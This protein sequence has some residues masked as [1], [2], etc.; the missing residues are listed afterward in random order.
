MSDSEQPSSRAIYLAGPV[1]KCDSPN[2]WRDRIKDRHHHLEFIDPMDWQ[3]E[4]E[5]DPVACVEKELGV[6]EEHPILVCN[7][8]DNAPETVGTHHEIAH[9]LASGNDHIAAVPEGNV[10]G[11]IENRPI[12]QFDTVR[13]ALD[14]LVQRAV[15]ADG[16][17]Q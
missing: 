4:W 3:D 14:Y 1:E 7:I 5:K 13:E 15:A 8:G 17:E 11:F 6:C 12:E 2:S 16:G 10:A 9:A